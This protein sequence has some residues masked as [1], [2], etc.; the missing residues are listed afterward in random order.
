MKEKEIAAASIALQEELKEQ[1]LKKIDAIRSNVIE[2][3]G[4][5]SDSYVQMLMMIDE[6]LDDVLLNW[7]YDSISSRRIGS[8]LDEDD[9]F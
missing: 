7:E 8:Y 3:K 4:S 6:D 2:D 5:T 9:D 1:I